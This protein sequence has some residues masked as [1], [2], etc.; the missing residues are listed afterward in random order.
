MLPFGNEGALEIH[1]VLISPCFLNLYIIAA[2]SDWSNH[3]LD[4]CGL[5]ML[6]F[7]LITVTLKSALLKDIGIMKKKVGREDGK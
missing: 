4:I 5:W 3:I 2:T 1:K 7:F 6:L